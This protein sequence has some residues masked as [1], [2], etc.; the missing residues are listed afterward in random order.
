MMRTGA[1]Q[2]L[3]ESPGEQ[4][5]RQASFA[6]ACVVEALAVGLLTVV[7]AYYAKTAAAHV[8]RYVVLTLS[9]SAERKLLAKPA[10]LRKAV[11]KIIAP[12]VLPHP[13]VEI[14]RVSEPQIRADIHA[15]RVSDQ[16][17]INPPAVAEARPLPP[18]P[19]V[20][21][22]GLFGQTPEKPVT[23]N[24]PTIQVQTGGF[25][26]PQGVAGQA[27]GGN[28][29]NVPK[30]GGFDLPEGTG[31][32][33]GSGGAQG[34]PQVVADAGFGTRR[35]VT[36]INKI[37]ESDTAHRIA[38]SAF[39]NGGVGAGGDGVSAQG[40]RGAVRTGAFAAP[41]PAQK[42][43]SRQSAARPEIRPIEILSKPSPQ[44]TE[45]ARRL[46]VQGEV[47]LSVVFQADGTLKVVGVIRSLGHGLD[48]MAEQAATQ[49]RFK[50][51][52]QAGKPTSFPAVLH[53]EFRLA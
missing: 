20:V 5:R 32:G 52:E 3:E 51:A 26:S 36:S 6:V 4:R 42:P 17:V 40:V 31:T 18:P 53:I 13:Q 21:H 44:Y 38:T 8:R 30:L 48:Q 24:T 12:H 41:E 2:L 22:T 14:P 15:P 33:N 9:S 35:E 50:P 45:E 43:A 1:F 7:C 25:G 16:P 11:P 28:P 29:G 47:V 27:Q 37:D 23:E 46:G 39:G 34:K 19:S 10:E 49:I